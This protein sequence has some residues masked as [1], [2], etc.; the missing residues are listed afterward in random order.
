M[1]RLLATCV[2]AA[3][4]LTGSA[5]AA[6]AVPISPVVPAVPGTS[7]LSPNLT[8]VGTIPLDG[9]GVAMR[10]VKVGAQVRAFVS[11]AGG[12]SIYDATDPVKPLLLGHLPIY[13]WENE[14]IAVSQDGSTAI[15]SEFTG[16]FYL[17]VIDVSNPALPVRAGGLTLA[18]AHTTECADPHCNYLFGSEGQTYDLTN[19]ASPRQLP[20]AQSW[21]ALTGAGFDGHNLHQDAA[22]IW[23]SDTN[24]L[25][26]FRQTPDPLH[27]TV[28]SKGTVTLN[29]NYQH[30]NL[31]PRADRFLP[32]T[33]TS[34]ALRDGELLLGEGESVEPTCNGGSGAFTTWSMVGFDRGVPL[35][36]LHVLRPVTGKAFATDPAVSA[37][38]C[39]GHRF[40]QKDGADG[41]ILVA[42]AWYEHG[43]RLLSVD[44]RTGTI[45]QV[46]FFQPQRGSASQA[47]WMPGTDVIWTIDY[48]SGIDILRFDQSPR[49]RPTAAA[50]ETSW[51]AR[52]HGLDAFS[53]A[54]RRLCRAGSTA[55]TED[56]ARLHRATTLTG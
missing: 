49:L 17:H 32:R 4:L 21:G 47:Y 45:A 42:A 51:L 41:K 43:T 28:L 1:R 7:L 35:K 40:T 9:V 39:S 26:V 23:I 36:Q 15:L 44:P 24:P 14:D 13:N 19:R 12:L 10:V 3:L 5:V 56:H 48:H 55:T 33:S 6:Q 18:G 22:G 31:R 34:G 11:G 20:T 53:E 37:L 8:H 52:L 46:G 16:S 50:V 25:V 54:L 27:L 38:A 30:N 2:T 29:S